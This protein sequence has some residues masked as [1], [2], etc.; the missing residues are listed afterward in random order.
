M[1]LMAS[2]ALLLILTSIS[3]V[4]VFA[5]QDYADFKRQ[6][7]YSQTLFAA[8]QARL[9][10]YDTRGELEK[11]QQ[12]P[13]EVLRLDLIKTPSGK[14]AIETDNGMSAKKSSIFYLTGNKETYEK[15]RAGEYEGKVDETSVRYR[16]LYDIFDG[17]LVD[18]SILDAAIALEYNPQ[19]GIVY[20]VLYSDKNNEFTYTGANGDGRVNICDRQEDY[21]S[22]YLIGYYGLE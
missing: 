10:S 17:Y 8:A 20:S 14:R 11:M 1:E 19:E 6:N 15:Y 13:G 4:G 16:L 9:T 21:R 18:K 3:V 12:T 7:E 5:Y 2:F 22:E